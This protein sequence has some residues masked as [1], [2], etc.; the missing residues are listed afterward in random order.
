VVAQ[1]D[2]GVGVGVGFGEDA[3]LGFL[4]SVQRGIRFRPAKELL[5]SLRNLGGCIFISI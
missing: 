5:V 3:R 4:E 2:I 1:V